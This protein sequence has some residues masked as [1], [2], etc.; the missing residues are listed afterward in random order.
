MLFVT[1]FFSQAIT[2]STTLEVPRAACFLGVEQEKGE[3]RRRKHPESI[4]AAT[5]ARSLCPASIHVNFK[6]NSDVGDL[7]ALPAELDE[8][9]ANFAPFTFG[10]GIK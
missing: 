9:F 8:I 2:V 4:E 10:K 5:H 7:A 1:W 3:T 6:A